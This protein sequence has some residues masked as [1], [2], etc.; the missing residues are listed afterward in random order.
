MPLCWR[1]QGLFRWFSSFFR[2]DT[3]ACLC[4]RWRW[5]TITTTTRSICTFPTTFSWKTMT[6]TL[7][8]G[9]IKNACRLSLVDTKPFHRHQLSPT[10]VLFYLLNKRYT[11]KPPGATRNISATFRE[12]L[13]IHAEVCAAQLR[14]CTCSYLFIYYL[15]INPTQERLNQSCYLNY[16]SSCAM[17][18]TN[19]R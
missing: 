8:T 13:V 17:S 12:H 1:A 16:C 19:C 6:M 18:W 3:R 4:N 15:F 9:T 7:G 2:L 5:T 11:D 10:T 14:H